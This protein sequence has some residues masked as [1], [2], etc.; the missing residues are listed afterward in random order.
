MTIMS[1]HDVVDDVL[2]AC[3]FSELNPVQR[4]AMDAGLMDGS[5]MVVA[6]PTASGKTLIAEIAMLRAVRSGKKALYIV[7][8]KA[9]ASEKYGEFREKYE[10]LGFRIAM[11]VGDR[12][13]SDSW[14]SGFDIIIVTSE[15]LDSLIRHDAPWIG[16]VGLVV[17]DEI[18]LIDSPD[19][20][21]TLEVILTR[22]RQLI[23]PQILALSATISNYKELAD[24]LGARAV[25]SDYRPVKLYNGLFLQGKISW[26]PKRPE[27][28]LGADLPPVFEIAKDTIRMGKQSLVFVST[29]KRA[30]SLAEKLGDILNP[31]IRPDEKRELVKLSHA[32]SHVLDHPTKQCERI[33]RCMQRGAVFHHAGLVPKQRKLIEDNFRSGLIKVI[34]STP[35]LAAGVNLPAFRVVVRDVKRFSSFRGMDYIPVLEVQQMM[36]RCVSGDT[37]I[38]RDNGTPVSIAEL[39]DKYF[40]KN[41]TGRKKVNEQI[42]ILTIDTKN[43]HV[44]PS[45]LTHIWKRD[46]RKALEIETKSG[47]R[48]ITTRDHPFLRFEKGMSGKPRTTKIEKHRLYKKAMEM[49]KSLGYGPKKIAES[50]GAPQYER[51]IQHWLYDKS[52][53]AKYSLIWDAA[54]NL[55]K[56]STYSETSHIAAAINYHITETPPIPEAFLSMDKLYKKGDFI[57]ITRTGHKSCKFPSVWSSQL[58]RFIAKI[59]ADGNI[60]F[61][62][63][64]NSYQIRYYNKKKNIH[65]AYSIMCQELFGKSISTFWR[66]GTYQS[67][68]KAFVIGNFLNNIGIP[69]GKKSLILRIPRVLFRLPMNMIKSFISEYIECDGY[70]TARSY[71]I[72]TCSEKLAYDFS[73]LFSKIGLVARIQKKGP[74]TLRKRCAWEISITKTQFDHGKKLCSVG[75]LHPDLIKNVRTVKN[76]GHFYDLTLNGQHNF[77]A[78]GLV[79]HNSGR[80]RY[81]KEGEAILIANSSEEAK[82]LW[83]KYIHGEPEKIVSKLGV[84]PVLR[85][86]VLSLIATGNGATKD[87]LLDFFSNTFYAHQFKD[88]GALTREI[89][90]VLELLKGYGFIEFGGSGKEEFGDF[91]SASSL[92]SK[93]DEE[94]KPT[95]I[96]KRV[97]E[98]YIDPLTANHIIGCLGKM[99]KEKKTT[100]ISILHVIS[101][102]LEMRPWLNIRKKDLERE[103]GSDSLIDFMLTYNDRLIGEIP[104]EWDVEYDGFLRSMKLAWMFSE[105]MDEAGEDALLENFGVTPGELRARLD[106]SD[107]LFYSMQELGMLL[108]MKDMV[109][110][111]R[112]ARLRVKYGIKEE[113]LPLIKLRNIGRVRARNLFNRGLRSLQSLR[114]APITSL[115]QILGPGIAK[116]VKRQLSGLESEKPADRQASLA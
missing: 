86:H 54:K 18:H 49:R 74:N 7:P 95:R 75:C 85:M 109:G 42:K 35:T 98:L 102:C 12:D 111:V 84:E 53:P 57:F 31:S 38:F 116:D 93:G 89:D 72:I 66:R 48:I 88:L 115:S 4:K 3:G 113:L 39:A 104:H 46:A 37:M 80:P 69:S 65:S 13:S 22:L 33:A 58:C 60:N 79:V 6:A 76:H 114:N 27:L 36:G 20:G 28:R 68:F 41:E 103:D 70:E 1:Q 92:A 63:N 47:K 8:L 26:H 16:S 51:M 25:K 23:N 10:K 17:A 40:K 106:M 9:L 97:A 99:V 83:N 90:N 73:L 91:R 24:W 32:V 94:I 107:W 44:R 30:E 2:K 14:L 108:G 50:L 11:S 96:G 77:I 56:S 87:S 110:H 78:N 59:M 19:R 71:V 67:N 45:S 61:S 52:V 21:P 5:N 101:Q 34:C 64:D 105:W 55:Q 29:R 112:K 100:N 82:H 62:P 81:D 43:H 15:K